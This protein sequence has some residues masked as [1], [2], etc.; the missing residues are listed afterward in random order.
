MRV[1]R[2][3]YKFKIKNSKFKN[4]ADSGQAGMRQNRG[5][6]QLKPGFGETGLPPK[7]TNMLGAHIVGT[8]QCSVPTINRNPKCKIDR[9]TVNEV[10]K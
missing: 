2:G 8:E 4:R 5:N 3:N 9:F 7:V 6:G 1:L 10:M